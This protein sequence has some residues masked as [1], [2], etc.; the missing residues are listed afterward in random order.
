V[1]PEITWAGRI[2]LALSREPDAADYVTPQPGLE[3]A[4]SLLGAVFPNF[5][6]TI[7]GKD[8]LEVGCRKGLQALG[9]AQAG[10]QSV[11]GLDSNKTV[12]EKARELAV[13]LELER[14]VEFGNSLDEALE[15]RFDVVVCQTM[16]HLPNPA[17]TIEKMK[18]A[19]KADGRMMITFSPPWYA[20][21]GS[22]MHFFTKMPW[23][24]LL[25]SEATVMAVRA[26]FRFDGALRYENVE[27]GLNKMT[28]THFERIVRSAG[29]QYAHRS[30]DGVRGLDAITHIP[31]V[32][33]LFTNRVSCILVS[34]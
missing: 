16:E 21:Y 2:L 15:R 22:H 12:T 3:N 27:G 5:L 26:R 17:Q 23:V 19:L 6:D 29:L 33:E 24:N 7:R 10:A 25:F 34:A 20:P 32:R 11:F 4:L 13:R 30:Y 8:I 9:M 18:A 31:F 1:T 14:R 28:L